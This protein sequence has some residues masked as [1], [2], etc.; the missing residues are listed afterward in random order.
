MVDINKMVN[1]YTSHEIDG[2]DSWFNLLNE[3]TNT[4]S[5]DEL[6]V[7]QEE[8]RFSYS[9]SI[10]RLIPTEAWGDPNS[11][12]REDI[13]RIFSVIRGGK[14]IKSRIDDINKFLTPDSAKRRKSPNVILNMMMIV[15]A[16]QATLNDYN[17]SAAGFVFEGFM[18]ALTG[19]K[20]IAGRVRGTLP[21]EDFVAFSEIGDGDP[22]SLKLLS[23]E[24]AI[25]GSFTNLIDYLFVRGAEKITYLVAFKNVV[26]ERVEKL[27]IFDFVISRDNIVD[28]L[29]RSNNMGVLGSEAAAK[30]LKAAIANW[31]GSDGEGLRE[32][33][34]ALND[35]PGYTNKG[36]LYDMG[37]GG[38]A[39][40]R[41]EDEVDTSQL[42]PE[43]REREQKIKDLKDEAQRIKNEISGYGILKKYGTDDPRRI[44]K[45]EK[46]EAEAKLDAIEKELQAL[47]S[48]LNESRFHE[49]E[50]NMMT[51]ELLL[52][53]EG[54]AKS[55]WSISRTAMDKMTD[56]IDTRSY[57][58]L[59]LSQKNIDELVKIYSAT[60]G[61][62]L[63]KLLDSTKVL[64]ENIGRYYSESKRKRAMKANE[65]GQQQGEEIVELLREDPK[66]SKDEEI[67]L[68]N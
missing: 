43:Q 20:Q 40:E 54:D 38:E 68:D 14:N 59:D 34:L 1:K 51:T 37:R 16:L 26:G 28:V 62:S 53:G 47:G 9:I 7:E 42:P 58:E 18:A 65:K 15:E 31:D 64:T 21:I 3:L 57:G 8:K 48:S 35:M 22:V 29:L 56:I 24:T 25:K 44:S 39:F 30:N 55:Q 10:P 66:Y 4:I 6:I 45:D 60:L 11:Q 46:A 32:I 5:K 67:D 19:G 61:D 13:T 52:E 41:P 17:E 49:V 2:L 63:Q 12:S 27:L 50:K 36:I 23:P 33:A